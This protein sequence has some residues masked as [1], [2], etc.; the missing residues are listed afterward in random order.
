MSKFARVDRLP[1]H[2]FAQVNELKMKM[3][4]AGADIID[5]GMG[6]PD[7]PTPKPILDKLTDAAHKAGN[8]KYSA[9]KGIKGLRHGIRDWYYR[10][11]N[12]SLDADREVCVTMGAK[13][14]LAHLALAMLS[15]V[16][17]SWHQTQ[18]TRFTRMPPSLQ[19]QMSAV[20]PSVLVR[21]SSRIWKLRFHT[22]GPSPSC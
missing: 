22:H 12:V 15:P 18:P 4:H 3:R 19:V 16:M 11:Y 5:L 20:F 17:S 2:V 14:G 7:V 9:S 13:E 1:L 10:R 21:I 6:N 8:S